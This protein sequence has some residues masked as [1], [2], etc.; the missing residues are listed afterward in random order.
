MKIT[1][2]SV[3]KITFGLYFKMNMMKRLLCGLMLLSFPAFLWADTRMVFREA[4]WGGARK[5]TQVVWQT[6]LFHLHSARITRNYA[7]KEGT[8]ADTSELVPNHTDS[9]YYLLSNFDI[10]FSRSLPAD[11]AIRARRPTLRLS[12]GSLQEKT[13]TDKRRIADTTCVHRQWVWQGST[14]DSAGK[15]AGTADLELDFWLADKGFKGKV[16]IEFFDQF[17]TKNYRGHRTFEG[18]EAG[19]I[20]NLLGIH[21]VEFEK[22]AASARIFPME[23]KLT[24]KRK[25]AKGGKEYLYSRQTVQLSAEKRE[26][27][28]FKVPGGY[29][30]IPAPELRPSPKNR[31]K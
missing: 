30:R 6:N 16:D 17:R 25:L 4:V 15:P 2:F 31:K 24:L 29:K 22:K 5:D 7:R 12:G 3:T 13:L 26:V 23:M 18:I 21:L 28:E 1:D 14:L 10:F 19:R 11:S 8:F 20:S 27:Q 9:V